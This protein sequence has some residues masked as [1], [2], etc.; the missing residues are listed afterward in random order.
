[1][2]AGA[3]SAAVER[4]LVLAYGEELQADILV[5]GPCKGQEANLSQG[6]LQRVKPKTLIRWERGLEDD[7]SMSIDFADITWLEGIE[8]VKLKETGCLTLRP[9]PESGVWRREEWRQR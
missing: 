6:W 9:D 1:M 2:W 7:S 4:E 8:V 3:V 5:Q